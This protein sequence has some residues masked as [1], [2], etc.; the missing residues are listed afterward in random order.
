MKTDEN[1]GKVRTLVRIDNCLGI[2]MIPEELNM[3][4]EMVRQIL[5]ANLNMKKVCQN[6]PKECASFRLENKCQQ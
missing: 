5:A 4:K 2:R 1:V 3:D 6:G